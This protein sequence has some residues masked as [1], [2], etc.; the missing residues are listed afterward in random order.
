MEITLTFLGTSNAMPTAARSHPAVLLSYAGN[1]ILVDCGEGTQRQFRK[2]NL[3]PCKLT[4]LLITHLHGDHV[5]GIPGLM[6]TLAMSE[7]SRVLK[8]YGPRGTKNHFSLL[9]QT[10]GKFNISYE[11]HESVTLEEKEWHLESKPMIHGISTN[12]YAFVIKDRRRLDKAKLRKLKLPNSPILKELQQGKDITFNT[13]KIKAKDVT[14]IEKGKKIAFVLDTKIND[15]AI[16]LAKNADLLVCEATYASSEK[17]YAAEYKHLTSE[18]AATIAKKANV[19]KLALTH[20]GQR[21]EHN[22]SIIEKEAKKIFKNTIIPK[23]LDI[24]II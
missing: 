4:H 20:I 2:A 22:L 24:L 12:A 15:N 16:A 3:N 1:A 8:I 5:L 19:K 7:Y 17:D 6:E 14:Y 9:E 21:Y 23:D 13:K 11:V 18:Q 10:Y